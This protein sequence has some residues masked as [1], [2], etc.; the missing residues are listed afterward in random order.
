MNKYIVL[1]AA[2]LVISFIVGCQNCGYK[3][4]HSSRYQTLV[5]TTRLASPQTN[6]RYN[7]CG[8]SN[9]CNTCTPCNTC[10]TQMLA[11]NSPLYSN[12]YAQDASQS[13]WYQSY[14]GENASSSASL[15]DGTQQTA[16]SETPLRWRRV[17]EEE[18]QYAN[19]SVDP[20]SAGVASALSAPAFGSPAPA[21]AIAPQY[22]NSS[23]R[24]ARGVASA[25]ETP[26]YP[27][28]GAAPQYPGQYPPRYPNSSPRAARGV[29]SALDTPGYP[30]PGAAPQYPNQY[31]GQY[32]N[33]YPRTTAG[34]DPSLSVPNHPLPRQYSN[35]YSN[36]PRVASGVNPSYNNPSYGAPGAGTDSEPMR[37]RHVTEE[38]QQYYNSPHRANGTGQENPAYGADQSLTVPVYSSDNAAGSQPQGNLSMPEIDPNALPSLNPESGTF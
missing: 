35:Q 2:A 32:P 22:P 3:T 29:A 19:S 36:S 16:Q 14:A 8:V 24:A 7:T 11:N 38:E 17:T 15:L 1:S 33:Q 25:L 31:P 10:S 34:V 9:A 5:G 13:G 6:C 21:S 23:R 20:T 37:W 18:Q 30:A 12:A 27:A 28:P 4:A 26:D